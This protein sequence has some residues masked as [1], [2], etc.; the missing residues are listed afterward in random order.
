MTSNTIVYLDQNYLSNMAKARVGFIDNKDL[1]EFWNSLFDSL[2]KAVL[3]DKIACP[4]LEFHRTEAM[5]DRRLEEPIRCVVDELSWGLGF[6]PS[7]D[8]LEAQIYQAAERFLGKEPE[9]KEPWSVAF[10]SNPHSPIKSRM[11]DIWG[12][13]TRINVH[14]SLS[15]EVV[16]H[17]R[18]L[19][20]RFVDGARFFLVHDHSSLDW[21]DL[22]RAEKLSFISSFFGLQAEQ[23]IRQQW[24][25]DLSIDQFIAAARLADLN[26]LW[27]RLGEIGIDIAG[28]TKV[29]DF[30]ESDELLGIPYIDIFCSIYAA[31]IKHFPNRRMRLGDFYDVPILATVLPYCNL[32]TTDSFMKEILVKILHFDD[33][34]KT[35]ILSAIKQD[36]LAFQKFIKTAVISWQ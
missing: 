13:K 19:K 17:D 2:K 36:R 18:R 14:L 33:K 16:E 32:V 9:E 5:Y 28:T 26:R 6:Y 11:Q 10:K 7:T 12:V 15:D 24:F 8:V 25:S 27:R 20:E 1:A 3:S 23:S 4:E 29:V 21:A 34:Y 35:K 22:V 31:I 30:L